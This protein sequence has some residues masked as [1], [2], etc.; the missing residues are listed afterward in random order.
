MLRLQ[1][2]L[3]EQ[4]RSFLSQ[5][6]PKPSS[7]ESSFKRNAKASCISQLLLE[8]NSLHHADLKSTLLSFFFFNF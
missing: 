1:G 2:E 8:E 6:P 7:M 5:E 4:S 3:E